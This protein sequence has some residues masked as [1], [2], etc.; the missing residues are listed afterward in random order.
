MQNRHCQ[1]DFTL[2]DLIIVVATLGG[3]AAL[4]LYGALPALRAPLD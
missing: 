1:P 3:L 4:A 2:G